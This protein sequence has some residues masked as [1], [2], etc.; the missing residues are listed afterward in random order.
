VGTKEGSEEK[1]KMGGIQGLDELRDGNKL[2]H[3]RWILIKKIITRGCPLCD[4]RS[5][6]LRRMS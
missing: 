6:K 1:D 2:S 3:R 4:D 5:C